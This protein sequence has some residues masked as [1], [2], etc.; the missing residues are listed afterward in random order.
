MKMPKK[1]DHLKIRKSRGAFISFGSCQQF[2][3]EK[4]TKSISQDILWG[5]VLFVFCHRQ[6]AEEKCSPRTGH[7]D[8]KFLGLRCRMEIQKN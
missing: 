2:S 1:K 3:K 6:K 7:R 5:A 8:R 4:E